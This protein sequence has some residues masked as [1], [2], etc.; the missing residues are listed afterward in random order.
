MAGSSGP[1]TWHAKALQ[2]SYVTAPGAGAKGHIEAEDAFPFATASWYFL[3]AL[4]MSAPRAS[5]G[6][7]APHGKATT[8]WV[9][10]NQGIGGNQVVG[11]K[12]YSPQKPFP[13]GP[14][15]KLHPNRAGYQAMGM[16]LI[17]RCLGWAGSE[18]RVNR[19]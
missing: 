18:L 9:V 17:W 13:G 2:S 7:A 6:T 1:M 16:G 4:D 14:G 10:I 3:D 12:E 19:C 8:R 5:S 11:P 15:D